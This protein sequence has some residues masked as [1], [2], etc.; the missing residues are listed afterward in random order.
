MTKLKIWLITP[1]SPLPGEGWGGVKTHAELLSRLLLGLGAELTVILP[2]GVSR[3]G[4][5]TAGFTVETVPCTEMPHTG[6]WRAAMRAAAERLLLKSVP[7][8]VISEGYYAAGCEQA[9]KKAGVPL[10]A[11]VH[12]FH[13]VHFS[14]TFAEVNGPVALFRYLGKALPSITYKMLAVEIPF[15]R[16][17]EL[18]ISVSEKNAGLLRAF[19]RVPAERLTV[20]HNWVDAAVFK[21]D[22]ALRAGARARLGLTAESICFLGAGALWRPKGFHVALQAFKAL[23]GREPRAVLMLA[24]EGP[25]ESALK[26][27]AG[28][29]LLDSGRVRF[30]GKVPLAEIPAVYNAADVFLMPSIHPEGLAYTLIEAM[31]CGLPAIATALGGNIETLGECGRLIPHS[32]PDVLAEAMFELASDEKKR[33]AVGAACFERARAAFSGESAE[34]ALRKIISGLRPGEN[35]VH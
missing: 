10:A 28:A 26:A 13:L 27:L 25:E 17:A 1:F 9:L 22:P 12:N 5:S 24:G 34:T 32:R 23:A 30:L 8:L 2:E 19:Y 14:K 20:L 29:P 21:A 15:L 11:F 6:K 3:Q 7:D 16:G 4:P 35:H 31:A 33:R 18:V